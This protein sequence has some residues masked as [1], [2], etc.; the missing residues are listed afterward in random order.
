MY[1]L[2]FYDTVPDYLERRKPYRQEHLAR[3]EKAHQDGLLVMAG[4]L[5]PPEGAVLICRAQSETEVSDFAKS[6]P[7]VKNGIVKSWRVREWAVAI[8]G[9]GSAP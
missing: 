1:Y 6:D 5:K 8:G 3:A 7:Y 4:A 2:L 9:E